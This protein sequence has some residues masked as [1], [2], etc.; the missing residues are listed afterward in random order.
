MS[1]IPKIKPGDWITI[2]KDRGK[3][4]VVCTVYEDHT[5]ADIEV[6]HIDGGRAINEDV[7]WSED[8][9]EFKNSGPSGGYADK[10]SRL[11][12]YVDILRKG[13]HN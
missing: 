1:D 12:D 9:W 11:K 6:V 10:Y 7:V 8:H 3:D 4:A 5:L 13:R 2:G